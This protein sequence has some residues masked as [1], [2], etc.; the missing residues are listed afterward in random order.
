ME[1]STG[2]ISKWNQ[3]W[4][5][6][7]VCH[8]HQPWVCQ[9]IR[10]YNWNKKG[11]IKSQLHYKGQNW[12]ADLF[13]DHVT[14]FTNSL[15]GSCPRTPPGSKNSARYIPRRFGPRYFF[16]PLFTSLSADSLLCVDL[17]HF[18]DQVVVPYPSCLI[19]PMFNI[20]STELSVCGFHFSTSSLCP[21][22]YG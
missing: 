3:P 1:G 16:P 22:P 15:Q 2:K 18:C 5:K 17:K 20:K 7:K 11:H 19:F 10:G 21:G 4:W 12:L 8:I 9:P 6:Q 13:S 14:E